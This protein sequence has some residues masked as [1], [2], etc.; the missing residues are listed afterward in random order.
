MLDIH[1]PL[2]LHIAHAHPRDLRCCYPAQLLRHRFQNHVLQFHHPLR[3]PDRHQLAWFHPAS[4]PS[5][6]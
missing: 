3:F 5:R 1:L 6:L 4:F 2:A